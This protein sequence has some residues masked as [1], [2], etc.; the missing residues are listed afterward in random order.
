MGE[1]R[2]LL[3]ILERDS[4]GKWSSSGKEYDEYSEALTEHDI[5]IGFD[6]M[7]RR[8]SRPHYTL[9]H[10]LD[11]S[12]VRQVK[13]ADGKIKRVPEKL[14]GIQ[15]LEVRWYPILTS[16]KDLNLLYVGSAELNT[17]A[18]RTKLMYRS[19]LKEA[20]P[21]AL[22]R[23]PIP[24]E[25]GSKAAVE[26]ILEFIVDEYN[27]QPRRLQ[28]GLIMCG[29]KNRFASVEDAKLVFPLEEYIPNRDAILGVCR[30]P[31]A[32]SPSISTARRA[33]GSHASVTTPS[34]HNVSPG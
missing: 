9:A 30:P 19:C 16:P 23:P 31:L 13:M 26:A 1:H 15:A 21:N 6:L 22:L 18:S 29:A 11:A 4:S 34:L 12:R 32:N 14:T 10:S 8:M 27:A 5:L 28:D 2:H 25:S 24:G 3:T 7:V 17:M 20:V 33:R